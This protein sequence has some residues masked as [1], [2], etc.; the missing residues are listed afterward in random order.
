MS[1]SN[2]D[3]QL[4]H[5]TISI[6]G[7]STP[8]HFTNLNIQQSLADVCSGSFSWRQEGNTT[9]QDQISFY[10]RVM[11]KQVDI[12]INDEFR[13]SGFITSVYLHNED[14]E[15]SE[16]LVSFSGLFQKLN[17]FRECD[18]W[19]KK[20]FGK[21]IKELNPSNDPP[22]RSLAQD[23]DELFYTVQ[24]NQ[25]TF[26]FLRM[27]AARL[28]KWMYYDGR[29]LSFDAPSGSAI[30][31]TKD[32][33]IQ[34]FSLF[35]NISH[36]YEQLTGFDTYTGTNIRTNQQ[37]PR[38]SGLLAAASQAGQSA[39]GANQ[40]GLHIAHAANEAVLRNMSTLQHQGAQ[41]SSVM[42]QAHTQ[43]S[44]LNIC[45]KIKVLELNG[46]SA[47]EFVIT[48]IQHTCPNPDSYANFINFVPADVAVPPYTDPI[49]YPV[50]EAQPAIVVDNVDEDGHDRIKV[51]FPWQRSTETTPWLSIVTP[52]AGKDKGMRFIP[53]KE[54]EVMVDF[55]TR[56]AERP[57][58]IGTMFTGN[59][60]SGHD[61]SNNCVKSLSSRSGRRFE[62]NDCDGTL[63]VFDNYSNRSPKN[64][65]LMKRKDE[66]MK[67]MIESQKDDSNYSVIVLNNETDLNLGVV[68]G[69]A[70][71]AQIRL[72]KDGKKITIKS[73]GSIDLSSGSITM[74]ADTISIKA[75]KELKL[76]GTEKGAS[77]KGKDI[78]LETTA[79]VSIKGVNVNVEASAMLGLKGGP[80]ATLQAS[81]VKIN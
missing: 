17:Q 11:G 71:V 67:I 40:T 4:T 56:N 13:F 38:A 44:R 61:V 10:E 16:Y 24:Y 50:C 14:E 63:K 46:S 45:G 28:G 22:I 37:A 73:E 48:R 9:L 19:M 27:M 51:R 39:Y 5:T 69:D 60:K 78:N 34:N 41:A 81:L 64:A 68:S 6:T 36:T 8:V 77:V 55:I 23:S 21:I 58:V 3:F 66:D 74:N 15:A 54:E 70:L 80:T 35:T 76:E 1:G 18:S 20:T 12:N 72:E 57:Y 25:T 52:Y 79:D 65:I 75:N 62:I 29:E 32:R 31:L 26:D 43:N 2:G 59:N 47:G 7:V 33:D 49:V 30:E 42:F 53:E